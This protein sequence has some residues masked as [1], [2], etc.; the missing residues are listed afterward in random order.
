MTMQSCN[1]KILFWNSRSILKHKTELECLL[2]DIDIFIGIETWLK[3]NHRL[4]YSNFYTVR[5]DRIGKIGGGIIFLIRKS[6]KYSTLD[7]VSMSNDKYETFGIKI[8]NLQTALNLIACYR[9]PG[10]NLSETEWNQ[11]I[12]TLHVKDDPCIITGDFNAHN[13]T[14]NCSHN[15]VNGYRLAN[16]LEDTDLFIHNT[17]S[18]T[19][20]DFYR[21]KFSNIDLILSSFSIADLIITD[22]LEDTLGSDHF[23]IKIVFKTEKFLFTNTSN[24][25]VSKKTDWT[26]FSNYLEDKYTE[27]LNINYD[28]LNTE[29]KYEFFISIITESI[30]VN[31]PKRPRFIKIHHNPVAWWDEECTRQVRIRKAALKKWRYTHQI[32]D[33]ISYKKQN[34]LTRKILKKKKR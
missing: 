2:S 23:P 6:L 5:Q 12:H 13:T 9:I 22:T 24:R 25:L 27:F 15:D 19:H 14:W 33:Y 21:N 11:L 29:N 17:T 30:I 1:L 3:G 32:T 4:N 20:I 8:T 31:T 34:A 7:R 26:G 28:T 16:T 10:N 18:L